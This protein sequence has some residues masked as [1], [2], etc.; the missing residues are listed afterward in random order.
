MC[1]PRF[2]FVLNLG[3]DALRKRVAQLT[4]PL[5]ERIDVP[6]HALGENGMFVQSHQL[7][8]GFR[9]QLFSEDRVRWTITFEYPVGNEPLGSA[10]CLYLFRS[11]AERERLRLRANVGDQQIVVAAKWV[12]RLRKSDEVAGDQPCPLMNRLVQR[13]L[14]ISALFTPVKCHG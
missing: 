12:E 10:F 3:D 11:L 9:R 1:E 13:M 8:E 5:V 7:A 2:V 6:D 4:P 14:A